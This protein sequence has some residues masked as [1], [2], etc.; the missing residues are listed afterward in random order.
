MTQELVTWV[1]PNDLKEG[2]AASEL[3]SR[4]ENYHSIKEN[5]LQVGILT[6]LHVIG[7][8]V[9]SGNLRLRIAK[10]LDFDLVP[11]LYV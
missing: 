7:D 5:I 4:P 2:R 9:V 1:N 8:V 10:E 3:Y 11:V 6:P